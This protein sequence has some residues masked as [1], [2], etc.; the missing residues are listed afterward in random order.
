M[1]TMP[2]ADT[3]RILQ[4]QLVL[5]LNQKALLERHLEDL[6]G[7]PQPSVMAPLKRSAPM[8]AATKVQPSKRQRVRF[9]ASGWPRTVQMVPDFTGPRALAHCPW[10]RS[11]PPASTHSVHTLIRLPESSLT[12]LLALLGQ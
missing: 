1:T 2:K 7:P 8:A 11:K 10:L 9:S 6:T 5:I 12:P 3:I 4:E